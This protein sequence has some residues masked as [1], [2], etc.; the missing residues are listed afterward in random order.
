[1]ASGAT[2]A[3]QMEQPDPRP[4]GALVVYPPKTNQL[5]RVGS[6]AAE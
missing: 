5:P 6:G 3:P 1:M 4:M 2:L